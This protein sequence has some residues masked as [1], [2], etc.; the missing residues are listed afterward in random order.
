MEETE[1]EK[2]ARQQR[3]AIE[4]LQR[5]IM[6]TH[7]GKFLE[8]CVESLNRFLT[9]YAPDRLPALV[10]IALYVVPV[11]LAVLFAIYGGR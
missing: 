1:Y 10:K 7:V 3:E 8:W 11:L 4:A 6:E 9:K 5:A 2:V